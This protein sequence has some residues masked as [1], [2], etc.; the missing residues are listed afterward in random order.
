MFHEARGDCGTP[1]VDRCAPGKHRR[2]SENIRTMTNGSEEATR[3]SIAQRKH[4]CTIL[5][6]AIL[7]LLPFRSS[8]DGHQ[9]PRST[10]GKLVISFNEVLLVKG[11]CQYDLYRWS[12]ALCLDACVCS[13]VVPERQ[14]P[15][16]RRL[17]A[18][19]RRRAGRPP[20][21]STSRHAVLQWH[22]QRERRHVH[23]RSLVRSNQYNL[24]ST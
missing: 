15:E 19:S 2:G 9:G 7:H 5:A 20:A 8:G 13:S 6:G 10:G 1:P 18:S 23:R 21:P 22:L 3:G 11:F 4:L 12:H 14:A 24:Q 17:W 16:C